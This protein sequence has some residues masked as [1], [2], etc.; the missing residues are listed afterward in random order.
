MQATHHYLF[1]IFWGINFQG[2][3]LLS[4]FWVGC[5]REFS[6]SQLRTAQ[7][8]I[9]SLLRADLF[10]RSL[11]LLISKVLMAHFQMR[12]WHRHLVIKQMQQTLTSA[13]Q[14]QCDDLRLCGWHIGLGDQAGQKVEQLAGVRHGYNRFVNDGV[15]S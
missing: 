12:D 10:S 4:C 5:L 11:M 9:S 2:F 15:P 8:L 3:H 7:V 6:D 1:T 14:G 13:V